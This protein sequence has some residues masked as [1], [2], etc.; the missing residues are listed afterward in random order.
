MACVIRTRTGEPGA[1][2]GA[3]VVLMLMAPSLVPQVA[4]WVR[5]FPAAGA[6]GPSSDHPMVDRPRGL[7][8]GHRHLDRWPKPPPM[9]VQ[10]SVIPATPS[11]RV[12]QQRRRRCDDHP[13][14]RERRTPLCSARSAP[15]LSC[16]G[17]SPHDPPGGLVPADRRREWHRKRIGVRRFRDSCDRERRPRA[18]HHLH[19]RES[20]VRQRPLRTDRGA[21]DRAAARGLPRGLRRAGRRRWPAAVAASLGIVVSVVGMLLSAPFWWGFDLPFA[22]LNAAVVL[23]F[24]VLAWAVQKGSSPGPGGGGRSSV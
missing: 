2:A 9:A 24:L 3:A 12:G 17:T 6:D 10:C 15:A 4:R 21:N 14:H 18:R 22:W 23:T 11:A 8:G 5:T 19:L 20:H 1:T 7:R 13:V 16:D